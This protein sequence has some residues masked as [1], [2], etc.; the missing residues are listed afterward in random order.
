MHLCQAK[1]AMCSVEPSGSLVS[2]PSDH[3]RSLGYP[4]T[5]CLPEQQGSLTISQSTDL[6]TSVYSTQAVSEERPETK[7]CVRKATPG[8]D[9]ASQSDQTRKSEDHDGNSESLSTKEQTNRDVDSNP[10]ELDDFGDD[11]DALLVSELPQEQFRFDFDPGDRGSGDYDIGHFSIPSTLDDEANLSGDTLP[12]FARHRPSPPPPLS[13]GQIPFSA[14]GMFHSAASDEPLSS[15]GPAQLGQLTTQNVLSSQM[16]DECIC[17]E[18][19]DAFISQPWFVQPNVETSSSL[20]HPVSDDS[21][22]YGVPHRKSPHAPEM[23]SI[24]SNQLQSSIFSQR[25]VDDP[26]FLANTASSSSNNSTGTNHLTSPPLETSTLFAATSPLAWPPHLT[27]YF[28]P[29]DLTTA[30]KVYSL[31]EN[32]FSTDDPAA[33]ARQRLMGASAAAAALAASAAQVYGSQASGDNFFLYRSPT[34]ID[35][36][37]VA[38]QAASQLP[39]GGNNLQ[40]LI[41]H[42]SVPLSAGLIHSSVRSNVA[43]SGS[44][45][46]RDPSLIPL[47]KMSV[48]LILTYKHINEVYYR[49]KR[50]LREQQQQPV[51]RRGHEGE[52]SLLSSSSRR[53]VPITL[54]L[55]QIIDPNS[56]AMESN[57][58]LATLSDGSWLSQV[59]ANSADTVCNTVRHNR[60]NVPLVNTPTVGERREQMINN[61]ATGLPSV[62]EY[63]VGNFTTESVETASDKVDVCTHTSPYARQPSFSDASDPRHGGITYSNAAVNGI[64]DQLSSIEL[65]SGIY[66]AGTAEGNLKD[67]TSGAWNIPAAHLDR[68]VSLQSHSLPQSDVS[69]LEKST[70]RHLS[71]PNAANQKDRTRMQ[72]PLGPPERQSQLQQQRQQPQ[73]QISGI[74]EPSASLF[75]LHGEMKHGP[76]SLLQLDPYVTRSRSYLSPSIEEPPLMTTGTSRSNRVENDCQNMTDFPNENLLST[77]TNHPTVSSINKTSA[78]YYN[79]SHLEHM[80]PG[81]QIGYHLPSSGTVPTMTAKL[82]TVAQQ[83]HLGQL[84]GVVSNGAVSA[85]RTNGYPSTVSMG[86]APIYA[87]G[88]MHRLDLSSNDRNSRV[89]PTEQHPITGEESETSSGSSPLLPSFI[90]ST[91]I[92]TVPVIPPTSTM[93]P[94]ISTMGDQTNIVTLDI[95]DMRAGD[96]IAVGGPRTNNL[97]DCALLK[98]GTAVTYVNQP[99]FSASLLG[100]NQH[101][102]MNLNVQSAVSNMPPDAIGG[103]KFPTSSVADNIPAHSSATMTKNGT[104]NNQQHQQP[105]QHVDRRHTDSNYDYIIRPG[106]L[107]LGRYLI[108]NLIGKGSFGQVMKAHDRVTNEDVAIKVIKNKRAFTNQAQVE[109][110]LLREM[111]RYMEESEATGEPPPLGANYVVRL[112]THFTFRGHLCLVFE[113]LS[114]NLYD[115]L[116]NTN[117]RGVS[118]NLTRKFA[119]QLCCALEFLSRPEL[120]IIH[121]D[122]K[123]ENILLVNP[124]RSAIKLVDFGSSCHLKEKVYQYIQS[125]FYRSPDVLLGLDYTMS[126]DMWSLGCILV[127]LHTGEP[128]FAGQNEIGQMMKIIEVLGMPPRNLLERSRRWHVF[129]ERTMDRNYIP[130]GACQPPGSRRL[131]D[132]LG[133]NS[134]GPRGRRLHEPGHS[135]ADYSVFM[136][137]VL[138]MLN[139]DPDRRI[140]P[141]SALAHR[142]FRRSNAIASIATNPDHPSS[143]SHLVQSNQCDMNAGVPMLVY[144]SSRWSG[145]ADKTSA[146]VPHPQLANVRTLGHSGFGPIPRPLEA[147]ELLRQQQQQSHQGILPAAAAAA[148]ISRPLPVM[149]G[150][151]LINQFSEPLSPLSTQ[152]HHSSFHQ[153]LHFNPTVTNLVA[154]AHQPSSS[155]VHSTHMLAPVHPLQVIHQPSNTAVVGPPASLHHPYLL[156]STGPEYVPHGHQQQQQT[157]PSVQL[158]WVSG[159]GD[160]NTAASGCLTSPDLL[161]VASASPGVWR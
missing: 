59:Y 29:S 39:P 111:N 98:Q 75:E 47:R 23:P 69:E 53:T 87:S 106:E 96:G 93:R 2:D 27:A 104:V 32:S 60:N 12:A 146:T 112:H 158:T 45:R 6:S 110:R 61:C 42:P 67:E 89:I 151:T 108:N 33:S 19:L 141:A 136:E 35:G 157:Q 94:R 8:P 132:I 37:G 13:R 17:G 44:L 25:S 36:S 131:S 15:P 143:T 127:E 50:R 114:Y 72:S 79:L 90:G 43:G 123:P 31:N 97:V 135:P 20:Y 121:C 82:S 142:F 153:S 130:K 152:H 109:I 4:N 102:H 54:S 117:F 3:N 86:A 58:S 77:L 40:Q 30:N 63:A 105:Q 5:E 1:N 124:K 95:K 71:Y 10:D 78:C 18:K 120:R 24:P 88:F 116:R 55:S 11:E 101:Q 52:S 107:W 134:G 122:L 7:R 155:R 46:F 113:L 159:L 133:V 125:R 100:G 64:A 49:K 84:T 160:Q 85:H 139:F 137:L 161:N 91:A 38:A 144:P 9:V 99:M 149:S 76:T 83:N 138:R 92:G 73:P 66:S 126:I 154:T 22:F 21:H 34:T 51:Q 70:L 68:C 140:R 28:R 57:P 48:N 115:L 74:P 41:T 26:S 103:P 118:L 14:E 80:I 145:F 56:S 16:S 156:E 62:A 150:D 119:Q 128:L 65:S 129:F 148:L 81:T 147:L